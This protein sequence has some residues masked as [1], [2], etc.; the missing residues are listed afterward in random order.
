MSRVTHFE[1]PVDDP[2]RAERFYSDVFGWRFQR[3]EGPHDYWLISTGDSAM[4]GIDGGMARR[5]SPEHA[6]A[7][8]IAVDSLDRAIAGV[9]SHGGSIVMP[10]A[11]VPGVGWL[12]YFRDP[13]GNVFGMMQADPNA[14]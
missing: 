8:T 7:N 3:W 6:L 2:P 4:P 9:E 5:Q 1:I 12:A 11:P 14:G 13:E 10:K